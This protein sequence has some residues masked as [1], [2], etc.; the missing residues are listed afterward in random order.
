MG[1]ILCVPGI[2]CRLDLDLGCLGCE[3]WVRRL[4]L[5]L[6][7]H[8]ECSGWVWVLEGC[9]RE[10]AKELIYGTVFGG[11]NILALYSWH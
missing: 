11:E 9:V 4:S 7:C 2:L 5:G 8:Y 10:F 3:G 6:C 1:R